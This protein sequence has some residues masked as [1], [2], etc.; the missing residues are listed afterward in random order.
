MARIPRAIDPGA[1]ASD[2]AASNV[3][4]AGASHPGA[5]NVTSVSATIEACT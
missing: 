2:F 4:S 5:S 1:G 3:I